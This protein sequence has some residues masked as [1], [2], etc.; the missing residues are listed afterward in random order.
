MSELGRRSAGPK[1][2]LRPTQEGLAQVTWP[3]QQMGL[4]LDVLTPTWD[5]FK[6]CLKCFFKGKE[7]EKENA[8]CNFYRR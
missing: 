6:L 1:H 8:Y 3:N 4:E 5:F 2:P 7:K